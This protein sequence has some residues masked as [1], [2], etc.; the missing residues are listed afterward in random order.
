[1]ILSQSILDANLSMDRGQ[2]QC[3]EL[4]AEKKNAVFILGSIG[5]IF[6][7]LV[8]TKVLHTTAGLIVK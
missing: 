4:A 5:N 2:R 7:I 1:M 8:L 3:R 6:N